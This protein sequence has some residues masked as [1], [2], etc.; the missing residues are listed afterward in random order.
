MD[1]L[2]HQAIPQLGWTYY[3]KAQSILP[4]SAKGSHVFCR[5][6]TLASSP[7]N[8]SGELSSQQNLAACISEIS[9]N[10]DNMNMRF[11]PSISSLATKQKNSALVC[12]CGA[13]R[14]PFLFITPHLN[15]SSNLYHLP[16]K[17]LVHAQQAVV[18]HGNKSNKGG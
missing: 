15:F 11:S 4:T 8:K 17:F 18:I 5:S 9:L 1:S 3:D 10:D 16:W 6:Q 13:G 7:P 14:F 12:S 2:C